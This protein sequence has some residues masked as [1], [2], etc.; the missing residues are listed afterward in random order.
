MALSQSSSK[1]LQT[2]WLIGLIAPS[3]SSQSPSQVVMP[4]PSVSGQSAE[5]TV[6][7]IEVVFQRS[8]LSPWLLSTAFPA[9]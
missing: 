5:V 9:P 6:I 3:L 8:P 4:S 7:W 1:P 2:S